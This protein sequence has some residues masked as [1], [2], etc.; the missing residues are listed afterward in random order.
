[1]FENIKFYVY[2]YRD[3]L[4][5]SAL[6][7][8]GLASTQKTKHFIIKNFIKIVISENLNFKWQSRFTFMSSRIA[9]TLL[10]RNFSFLFFI[11]IILESMYYCVCLVCVE[12]FFQQDVLI[13]FPCCVLVSFLSIK[14]LLWKNMICFDVIKLY[15]IW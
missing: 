8:S 13:I 12:S 9:T 3:R 14:C 11:S 4:W 7:T 6:G 15:K 2:T 5:K 1:M 10:K